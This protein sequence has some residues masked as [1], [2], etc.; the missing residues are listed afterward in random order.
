MSCGEVKLCLQTE[1]RKCAE[2]AGEE[3]A[4]DNISTEGERRY[5]RLQRKTKWRAGPYFLPDC[6]YDQRNMTCWMVQVT[7]VG[8]K[9][10]AR[11]VVLV[12]Y[13][14][15][16]LYERLQRDNSTRNLGSVS[17]PLCVCETRK[18]YVVKHNLITEVYLMTMRW[19]QLH[20]YS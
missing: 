20:A 19:K 3:Y 9:R 17:S 1:G 15:R 11:R 14:E 10:R 2:N 7:F 12:K 13:V 16:R 8:Y 4:K 6:I 18:R 5:R